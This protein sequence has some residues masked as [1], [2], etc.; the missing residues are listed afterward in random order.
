MSSKKERILE[1]LGNHPEGADD[2]EL[3][4]A[5][6]FNQ[7]QDAYRACRQLSEK[8]LINREDK[9]GHKIRNFSTGV[10]AVFLETISASLKPAKNET[11]QISKDM[12]DSCDQWY[13]EGNVQ[14]AVVKHLVVNGHDIIRVCQTASRERGKD[15]EAKSK[16]GTLW[17]TV[18]GYPRDTERTQATTQAG[19]W[20]SGALFDIVCWHGENP[21][22]ELAMALPDY[23]RYRKLAERASWLRALTPFYLI[24]VKEDGTIEVQS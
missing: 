8:G 22:N 19:H 13:W 16:I 3:A 18:K 7:R 12:A 24:W 14:S 15:I 9:P 1:Y 17:V 23:P 20:F 11:G 21:D 10:E 4:S 2:D 5:L 6:G